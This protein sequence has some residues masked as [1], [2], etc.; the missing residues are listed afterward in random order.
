MNED[1]SKEFKEEN[2]RRTFAKVFDKPTIEAIHRLAMKKEFEQLE[3]LVSTGKEAHVFR[4]VDSSENFL[5]VKVYKI[6]TSEFRNM[7]QYLQGDIRFMNVRKNK[8][9]IVFA[10][11]KKEYKNLL[12]ASNA[13]I[14]VPRPAAFLEN[15]LVMEFIGEE[16]GSACKPL[17]EVP[18][19]ELDL[20]DLFEQCIEAIAGLYY[21]AKLVHADLSEY[22]ILVQKGRIR[23]ID[24][25]Q[26]VLLSHP[27]AK[28]FF[29]RDL[30]NISSYF[31][32]NGLKNTVEE[33][34]EK[35]REK[36]AIME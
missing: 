18:V 14:P 34:K 26:A 36:K 2:I 28:E 5:A 33:I 30:R 13:G 9:D 24:M 3:F 4:A 25:G 16:D 35:I 22:N 8:R 29:G 27:R 32:K 21:K 11:T 31:A 12:L 23:I 20:E 17:N 15:I 6:Q 1:F 10:W 19:Q 7:Q